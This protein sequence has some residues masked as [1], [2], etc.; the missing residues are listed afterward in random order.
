RELPRLEH[1]QELLLPVRCKVGEL[2]T[3]R[4]HHEE[5]PG[6]VSGPVDLLPSV[7]VERACEPG[8]LELFVI[9]EPGEQRHDCHARIRL[10]HAFEGTLHSGH[11]PAFTRSPCLAGSAAGARWGRPAR[12]I[13]KALST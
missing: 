2:H 10:L 1:A 13:R 11:T 7:A 5:I 9:A 8:D 3:A 4:V 6:F 12:T